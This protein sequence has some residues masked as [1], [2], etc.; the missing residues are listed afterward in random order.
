MVSHIP[1]N[2][3]VRNYFSNLEGLILFLSNGFQIEILVP[4]KIVIKV[5]FIEMIGHCRNFVPIQIHYLDTYLDNTNIKDRS[6]TA[7]LEHRDNTVC[8]IIHNVDIH[9]L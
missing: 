1:K 5:P 9:F 2:K 7:I 4:I 6:T 8:I 3:R